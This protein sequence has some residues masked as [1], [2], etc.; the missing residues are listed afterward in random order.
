MYIPYISKHREICIYR[1][2]L[3]HVNIFTG[4]AI[5]NKITPFTYTQG[6]TFSHMNPLYTQATSKRT[7]LNILTSFTKKKQT[8]FFYICIC[9]TRS[10]YFRISLPNI[11]QPCFGCSLSLQ[12]NHGAPP[13]LK[14][15]TPQDAR[16][17]ALAS[18]LKD[19]RDHAAQCDHKK[20][21]VY[22]G[23]PKNHQIIEIF[24]S[25]THWSVQSSTQRS[26]T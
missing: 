12:V 14:K 11:L 18:Q 17:A 5:I 3:I 13:D 25:L 4:M 15:L 7:L 19:A 20:V 10:L 9:I 8:F 1:S 22:S 6:F 16:L 24:S 26:M 2:L 21:R 23:V